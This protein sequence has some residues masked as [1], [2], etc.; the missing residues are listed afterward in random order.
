MSDLEPTTVWMV[1]LARGEV[2]D[3]VKGTLEAASGGLRFVDRRQSVETLIPYARIHR[4]KR[5]RVSPVLM[6][7]W[8]DE[9]RRRTAFYFSQPPPL[10]P[11]AGETKD[12]TP[13]PER[14]SPLPF[15]RSGK[16]K[17]QRVNATYLQQAG[18]GKRDLIQSWAEAVQ[19]RMR[20]GR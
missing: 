2:A 12:P 1:H 7:E 13:R 20:A 11:A 8:E 19:E 16:R 3:D 5:L 9:D 4:V 10:Y 17:A 18:M 14:I 6:V 15:K